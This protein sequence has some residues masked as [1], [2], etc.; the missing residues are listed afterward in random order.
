MG[1]RAVSGIILAGGRSRRLGIDKTTMP[2]PPVPPVAPRAAKTPGAPGTPDAGG[3]TDAPRA[4]G[5]GG[6]KTLLE[7]TG[8]KLARV[9]DDV[10]LV[11]YRA[12]RPAPFQ[13]VPD[14]Y[15]EGG[16]LGGLYSGLLACRHDY[17][18]AVAT[19]MPFLSQPLLEWM[20]AQ[21]R[22]FD[23]LAPANDEIETL[24]TLYSKR[25]LD[26]MKRRLDAGKLR[27]TGVFEDV[28]VRY[29][30]QATLRAIDPD[31]LSFFNV[32][33]PEDLERA[34]TLAMRCD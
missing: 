14:V 13:V 7:A 25:C 15:A 19:D 22:D 29:V 5:E 10:V 31:G 9:C 23:V 16:S 26:A 24:H 34:R 33:T 8:Q 4:P 11:G 17:A 32:N 1:E 3:G 21:P 27:I 20:L 6:Q 30:D 2:W 18:L 12:A 28:R